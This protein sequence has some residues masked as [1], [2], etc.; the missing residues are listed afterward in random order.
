MRSLAIGV[1]IFESF[2]KG[3]REE[4]AQINQLWM[5]SFG[6]GLVSQEIWTRRSTRVQGE[7][8]LLCGLLHD[9][10][11]VFYFK[12]DAVRYA[13]LFGMEKGPDDPDIS[14][15]ESDCYGVNHAA[16]GGLLTKQ[17]NLPS[18]LSTVVRRHHDPGAGGIPL[19]AAVS[20]AD[21]LIKKAGIGYD[22]DRKISAEAPN[23]QLLLQ[24][25][26]EELDSL[27]V[28]VDAKRAG[29]EEFFQISS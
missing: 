25:N 7:F 16:L 3:L 2:T 24:M 11:K 27:S 15:L 21:M 20:L 9:L 6:V 29:V 18:D 12:K 17:W 8:A 28:L 1:S 22:G 26:S 13:Q 10:G 19:V 23:L 14:T 4:A 5:H